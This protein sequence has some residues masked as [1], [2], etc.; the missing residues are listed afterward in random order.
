LE[1]REETLKQLEKAKSRTARIKLASAKE[2]AELF[3]E[4]VTPSGNVPNWARLLANFKEAG[5]SRVKSILAAENGGDISPLL[6][7][8]LAWIVA[9]QDGTWYAAG[10]AMKKLNELGQ[11]EDQIFALDGD[12]NGFSPRDQSLF[13]LAKNLAASPVILTTEQVADAV[14]NSGPRDTVQVVSYICSRASFNRLTESTGL[15]LE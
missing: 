15:P 3:P 4:A 5:K 2:A 9:R 13:V 1:S 11:T 7:A 10:H 12:L 14:K 6:K 8:Q